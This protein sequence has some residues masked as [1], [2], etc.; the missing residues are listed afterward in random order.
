MEQKWHQEV[1]SSSVI[2]QAEGNDFHSRS[3]S[4]DWNRRSRSTKDSLWSASFF[5]E[6]STKRERSF[7]ISPMSWPMTWVIFAIYLA[8]KKLQWIYKH[9]TDECENLDA[10]IE[11]FRPLLDEET[12]NEM[13]KSQETRLSP[14]PKDEV[15]FETDR[16]DIRDSRLWLR[17][18]IPETP[19]RLPWGVRD[20]WRILLPSQN[21][22]MSVEFHW[23]FDKPSCIIFFT[24]STQNHTQGNNF[25]S[26]CLITSMFYL[27]KLMYFQFEP[28][29]N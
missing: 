14:F 28:K 4:V 21:E 9:Y 18:F 29:F 20:H 24:C 11:K 6:L 13:M 22:A 27:Y 15:S 26:I 5:K 16:V 25:S 10:D 7:I 12:V 3:S 8:P 19:W 17:I 1:P 23:I 2:H